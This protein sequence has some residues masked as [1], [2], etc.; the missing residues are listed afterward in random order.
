MT[1]LSATV[2]LLLSRGTDLIQ[3]VAFLLARG[4]KPVSDF[5]LIFCAEQLDRVLKSGKGVF[6]AKKTDIG[7]TLLDLWVKIAP[8]RNCPVEI[9]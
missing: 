7:A 6:F 8:L 2:V 4:C 9:Y 3:M 1:I 5:L